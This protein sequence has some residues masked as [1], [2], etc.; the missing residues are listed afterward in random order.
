[1]P[2]V[3]L[4]APF[5]GR[6]VPL[7]A[8]PAV[9]VISALIGCVEPF[10]RQTVNS[11][12]RRV[13]LGRIEQ[14][15]PSTRPLPAHGPLDKSATNGIMMQVVDGGQPVTMPFH[16]PIDAVGQHPPPH[17]VGQERPAMIARERQFADV[18]GVVV[19]PNPFSM[20][21]SRFHALNHIHN[22]HC[23]TSQQWH[24]RAYF[25]RWKLG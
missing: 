1:M 19:M 17:V 22:E 7:L 13:L 20:S 10:G 24:P 8:C 5:R 15:V 16:C 9:P 21:R 14:V 18:A 11:R 23:W 25:R 4:P 6:R 12:Q 2:S 3:F